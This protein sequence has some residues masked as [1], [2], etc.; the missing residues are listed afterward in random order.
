MLRQL[1]TAMRP[2]QWAKNVLVFAGVFFD[3]AILDVPRL[4]RS[5]VAFAIFCLLSSAVYLINDLADVERDRL[6]PIKRSR[7]LA[8]GV[9]SLQTA[10]VAAI[11]SFS[12]CLAAA[13]VLSTPFGVVAMIYALMMVL[14]SF[15]LKNVVIIDVMTVA[16]GF[17]LRVF[18]GTTVVQVTRFSPWLYVCTTLLA[19]FVAINKRRHELVL[20]ADSAELH[21]ISLQ[22][23]NLAFLNDM[24]T[25]VSASALAAYSFYTFSAPNLPRNHTMMLTIPFVMYCIFRYSYLIHVHD[26]GGTPEDIVFADRP[27]LVAGLL[28]A[29]VSGLAIY[30]DRFF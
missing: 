2:K 29:L 6:H 12:A 5:A 21:R 25:V 26:L 23:Y 9:L 14:Y 1:L 10:K 13:F 22:D 27:L 11:I 4:G 28:W 24:A 20:L 8:S 3:G 19:L 17:V 16:A 15:V 30:S 7:P 18:A